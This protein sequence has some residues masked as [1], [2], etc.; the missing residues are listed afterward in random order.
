LYNGIGILSAH[1][2]RNHDNGAQLA[3]SSMRLLTFLPTKL[4]AG[5]FRRSIP[6]EIFLTSGL[7]KRAV[8]GLVLALGC[9][10]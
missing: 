9:P 7:T 3:K 10:H 4:V 5:L 1:R 2:A 6:F 8:N